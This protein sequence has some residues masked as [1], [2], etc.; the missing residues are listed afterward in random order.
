[1]GVGIIAGT[2]YEPVND[3]DLVA[4]D[5][6]NLIP[7]SVTKLAYLKQLYLPAYLQYFIEEVL[8]K[9]V[10]NPAEDF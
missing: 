7:R 3:S 1:L 5:L 6:S 2:S 10:V 4:L 8:S 9:G